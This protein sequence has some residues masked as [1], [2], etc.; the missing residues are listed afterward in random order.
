VLIAKAAS[1]YQTAPL[2]GQM[3]RTAVHQEVL[4]PDGLESNQEEATQRAVVRLSVVL[5]VV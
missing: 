1:R 2:A 4:D 5:V 3:L